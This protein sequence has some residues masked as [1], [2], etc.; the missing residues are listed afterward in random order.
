M[1]DSAEKIVLCLRMPPTGMRPGQPSGFLPRART[2]AQRAE[3]LGGTLAAWSAVTIAFSFDCDSLEEAVE[4]VASTAN[5]G[6]PSDERWAAGIARG[7]MEP[8]AIA[9]AGD[10]SSLAWGEALVTSLTLARVARSGEVLVH[11]SAVASD[12]EGTLR[13]LDARVAND[14]GF[15]VRGI[16]LDAQNPWRTRPSVARMQ[17]VRP[18]PS[19]APPPLPA[20]LPPPRAPQA[21]VTN[22]LGRSPAAPPAAI[23]ASNDAR[24]A[25]TRSR[26]AFVA[27]DRETLE[28]LSADLGALQGVGARMRA[29]VDLTRGDT[30]PAL[31]TLEEARR[32]AVGPAR[33]QAS[34]ALA[35]ALA[36][37][38]HLDDA[39]LEGLD[40]LAR[41]REYGDA[42]AARAC[43]RFL[44]Q[45][46]E[47]RASVQ[48]AAE[49]PYEDEESVDVEVEVE[50]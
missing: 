29:F 49:D 19:P 48:A 11:P 32:S 22:E 4:L 15:E 42:A 38:G 1:T 33:S 21:S 20:P 36:G 46:G 26:A 31:R 50:L 9:A 6:V 8:L 18:D 23:Q 47:A 34:L 37:V 25:V 44:E 40:A 7:V 2:L 30:G 14:G 43:S 28:R 39:L 13:L 45:L 17:A 24:R 10:R 3:A 5:E 27:R 35:V 12:T 16:R 41:A